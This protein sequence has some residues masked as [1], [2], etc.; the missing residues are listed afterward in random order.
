MNKFQGNSFY[1]IINGKG[2]SGDV[3]YGVFSNN[4]RIGILLPDTVFAACFADR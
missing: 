4:I 3:T 1:A 2:R